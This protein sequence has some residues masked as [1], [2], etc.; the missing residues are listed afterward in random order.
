MIN[1]TEQ[2]LYDTLN[3]LAIKYIRYEHA[4]ECYKE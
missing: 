2:K 1:E 3:L 4:P